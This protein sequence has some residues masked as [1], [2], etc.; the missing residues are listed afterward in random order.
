MRRAFTYSSI[1]FARREEVWAFYNTPK[2]LNRIS[3]FYARVNVER[4][5]LPLRL[6]SHVIIRTVWPPH[7]RWHVQLVEYVPN[8]HFV[9]QLVD[10]P[11]RTWRHRHTFEPCD[12]GTRLTDEVD[13]SLPSLVDPLVRPLLNLLLRRHF[14]R[15]HKRTLQYLESLQPQR[16]RDWDKTTIVR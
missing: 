15:R 10:G 9:D 8:H 6:D 5:D 1:I 11:F 4:A 3:P 14:A 16:R 7:F 12:V 2:S 13:Y